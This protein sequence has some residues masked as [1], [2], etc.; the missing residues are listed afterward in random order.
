MINTLLFI[1]TQEMM[2]IGVALVVLFGSKQIPQIVKGF[3]DVKKVKDDITEDI[4]KETKVIKDISDI[5]RT[6]KK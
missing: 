1:G 2:I 5:T 4:M 6:F 3:K